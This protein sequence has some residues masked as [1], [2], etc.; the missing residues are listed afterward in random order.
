[1]KFNDRDKVIIT[2]IARH[3]LVTAKQVPQYMEMGIRA[4][5]Y[6]HLD[7]YKRQTQGPYLKVKGKKRPTFL[8]AFLDDCS[9]V[10]PAARFSFTEKT[11]DL[12]K[13]LE[14]ALLRRGIPK[15]IYAD[16]AKIYRSDQ[17]HFCLLYTSAEH[18]AVHAYGHRSCS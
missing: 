17:F 1:M 13:V 15:M 7:V 12:M 3:K 5:S 14:E 6:T 16:N 11:E 18:Q 8:L 10:V 4:V 9:R 2:F